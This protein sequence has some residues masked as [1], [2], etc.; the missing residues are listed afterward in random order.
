[1]LVLY[2]M[3]IIR[4]IQYVH[5]VRVLSKTFKNMTQQAYHDHTNAAAVCAAPP[6]VGRGIITGSNRQ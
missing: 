1:M 2:C 6:R 5:C 3:Y 4:T